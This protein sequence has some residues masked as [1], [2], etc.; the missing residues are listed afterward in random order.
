MDGILKSIHV[1]A[2][3]GAR[4]GGP[5][6]SV[7]RLV[8]ALSGWG[9]SSEIYT[10]A[11]S[12]LERSEAHALA[13][14]QDFM[15]VPVASSLRISRALSSALE[16]SVERIDILHN[17]GLWLMPNVA[18]GRIAE[19][20]AKPLVVSPRGMLAFE[21]LR[22]SARKKRLFWALLQ[23]PAL[24]QAAVWHA[25]CLEEAEDIRSFG[26]TKPIAIIPN[27][28]DEA[29]VF[30]N[31]NPKLIKR[32]LLFM[33]RIHPKKGLP[34]L[35]TAWSDV[36]PQRPNW[37]LVIAGPDEGAHR[38]E[39]AKQV[40]KLAAPS[41]RFV[42]PV[43]G[44]AKASLLA[45]ADLF[46]LPTKSENFGIAV[47]EAL[48]AGVPAIVTKGAPWSGLDDQRCGWWIDHGVEPLKSALLEATSLSPATRKE[49][50]ARGRIWMTRE[51]SWDTIASQ[52]K[53]V[54]QWII[55]R[56]E[57]PDCIYNG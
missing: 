18:V 20:A 40:K 32:T 37:E 11:E 48:A 27:G 33:S 2:G 14:P 25:T 4:N 26:V 9:V 53:E 38:A 43:Y 51:F 15:A 31:H 7:P 34:N 12:A 16:K 50:G 23:G 36:A 28:I 56:S 46:V 22:F 29:V 49:M 24:A 41:V 8:S 35:I 54:Y 6:Y 21:A 30:A 19:K 42:D 1:I 55:S 57:R 47:A 52:M 3:L 17:H 39:L 13:F 10:V 44:H 45:S 5:S